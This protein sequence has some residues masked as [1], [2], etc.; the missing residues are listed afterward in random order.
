MPITKWD[1]RS[2][3]NYN[4]YAK[5]KE[6]ATTNTSEDCDVRN[7]RNEGG[8]SIR[9][10]AYCREV[11]GEKKGTNE[12]NELNKVRSGRRKRGTRERMKRTS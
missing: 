3:T 12:V 4:V 7:N 11:Y 2:T 1:R 5:P 9:S 10:L 8:I 6:Q